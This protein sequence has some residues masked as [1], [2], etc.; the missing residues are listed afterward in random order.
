MEDPVQ[1]LK[2]IQRTDPVGK[3]QWELYTEQR[4]SAVRD[5][6]K[7]DPDFVWGFLESY[8]SGVRIEVKNTLAPL[9][10]EG[11]RRS[12]A[13]KRCWELYCQTHGQKYFDPAKHD[14]ASL[15]GFLKYLGESGEK[16]LG[17]M[18]NVGPPLKKMNT[19]NGL[20]VDPVK[21]QLVQAVKNFQ[22][23]SEQNKNTWH[24][25]CDMNLAGKRDPAKADASVL[26]SFL[27]SNGV[28]PPSGG[29]IARPTPGVMK[30]AYVQVPTGADSGLVARIKAFQRTGDA[31]RDQWG[32]FA[33]THLGGR[34]DPAKADPYLL[35]EFANQHGI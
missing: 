11:Q 27:M 19:G 1:R 31:E 24:S 4:G 7:H 6:S 18:H 33:D 17:G 9:M 2:E 10:K 32:M 13:W 34:R 29:A 15:E 3:V 14:Q 16:M 23:E 8:S 30:S 25:F 20:G 5:P 35:Q 26:S 28:P 21:E 22:K 12:P